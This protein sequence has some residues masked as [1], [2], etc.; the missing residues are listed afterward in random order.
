MYTIV[1]YPETKNNSLKPWSAADEL[2]LERVNEQNLSGKNIVV[3]NDRFGYLSVN[4]NSFEPWIITG[5]RSQEKALEGNFKI[6]GLDIEPG[7]IIRLPEPPPGKIDIALIRIPKSIELFRLF[8]YLTHEKSDENTEVICSFM[9][10][11]FSPQILKTAE[12]FFEYVEQSKAKKKA[13]LLILKNPKELKTE[14]KLTEQVTWKNIT[15]KQYSGVFSSS[16]IDFATRFLLENFRVNVNEKRILDLAAGNG[17]IGYYIL[18]E[19]KKQNLPQP[20]L[21]LLDDSVLAVKSAE[22]N[23]PSKCFFHYNDTLEDLKENYF[24]LI[25]TNPPFHFEHEINTE[26]SINLFKESFAKLKPGGRFVLVFNRHLA[27]KYK[28][29]LKALFQKITLVADSP[30]YMILECRKQK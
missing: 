28:P 25:I 6:N 14:I 7:H 8:L 16:R 12:L 13:R 29:V 18:K 4:L 5:Y 22:M 10:K 17:I 19:Y 30:K 11:Y 23:L 27:G 26:I 15:L 24:D 20:E 1:R 9:T 2:L 21:H 3:F